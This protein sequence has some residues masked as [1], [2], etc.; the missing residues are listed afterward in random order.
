MRVEGGGDGGEGGVDCL[1]IMDVESSNRIRGGC[2]LLWR[3]G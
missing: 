2:V 3:I 1:R